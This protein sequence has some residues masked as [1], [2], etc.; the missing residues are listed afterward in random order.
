MIYYSQ[1]QNQIKLVKFPLDYVC[2]G[3]KSP[4]CVQLPEV[5]SKERLNAKHAIIPSFFFLFFKTAACYKS[6][7][8]AVSAEMEANNLNQADN[9]ASKT[10]VLY[11]P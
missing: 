6:K 9:K 4:L 10:N 1:I 11:L 5:L 8:S 2:D 7:K 3:R